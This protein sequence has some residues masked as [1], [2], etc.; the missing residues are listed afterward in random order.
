MVHLTEVLELPVYDSRGKKIGRVAELAASPTADPP[1]VTHLLVKDGPDAPVRSVLLEEVASLLTNRVKLRVPEEEVQAF[2]PDDSFLLLRK[3]LLDQQIIDVHGRKVVRVNDLSLQERVTDYPELRLAAVDIG[4]GGALRRLCGGVLPRNWLRK[5]E[6]RVKPSVIPWA[7]VDLLE[8]DPLRRVK[9]RLSHKVLAR[10][11]PA[12]LADIVEKLSPKERQAIFADLDDATVA[13]A[14]SEIQRKLQVAILDSLDAARAADIVE[15]M[16]PDD[17]ADLLADLP[18]EKTSELLQ[19]MPQEEAEELGELLEFSEHSAGGLMTTDYVAL[20]AAAD[21]RE[22]RNLLASLPEFPENLTTIFLVEDE[23]RFAGSVAVGKLL[24]AS[25]EQALLG[26][27]SDP[28]LS[29]PDKESERD[30]FELFD[31]Y[32]LLALPVVDEENRLAGVVT[33]DDVITAL[34]KQS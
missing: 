11:H 30:V 32:N 6:N 34:R 27:R 31:K 33:V 14:L 12:D 13:E 23:G 2:Q 18:E 16:P 15:E 28:P 20:P 29:I 1:R 10:L 22:A 19:D 9:L 17:A 24:V 26:L 25:P 5:L 21:V 4:L 3:D 8:P 7:F